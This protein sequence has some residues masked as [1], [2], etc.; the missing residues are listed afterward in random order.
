MR[1][2]TPLGLTDDNRMGDNSWHPAPPTSKD[3]GRSRS[4]SQQD[5]KANS[6]SEFV[7]REHVVITFLGQRELFRAMAM[8]VLA[9]TERSSTFNRADLLTPIY[10]SSK[11][12]GPSSSSRRATSKTAPGPARSRS[13]LGPSPKPQS[14][15]QSRSA[16]RSR[17]RSVSFSRPRSR[18]LSVKPIPLPNVEIGLPLPD[19]DSSGEDDLLIEGTPRSPHRYY[20]SARKCR[21]S[22]GPTRL[23]N[24]IKWSSSNT[25]NRDDRHDN[26]DD[27]EDAEMQETGADDTFAFLNRP[28][29]RTFA[30]LDTAGDDA[31]QGM[32][33]SEAP[34]DDYGGA[35]DFGDIDDGI[36]DGDVEE[37]PQVGNES[38]SAPEVVVIP[39]TSSVKSEYDDNNNNDL[40]S[41]FEADTGD[42]YGYFEE[43][44]PEEPRPTSHEFDNSPRKE[45]R[46]EP[47][48][49][50]K[51]D[52]V[53][54]DHLARADLG[55]VN[56]ASIRT[57]NQD[58][59]P[60]SAAGDA[61]VTESTLHPFSPTL[62]QQSSLPWPTTSNSQPLQASFAYRQ[63]LSSLPPTSST[64]PEKRQRLPTVSVSP[65]KR[66]LF[67]DSPAP[68]LPPVPTAPTPR[69]PTPGIQNRAPW[70]SPD[71]GD[72]GAHVEAEDEGDLEMV[73]EDEKLRNDD[74]E[75]DYDEDG[76]DLEVIDDEKPRHVDGELD[77]DEDLAAD[78][79]AS[80]DVSEPAGPIVEEEESLELDDHQQQASAVTN[81]PRLV[82]RRSLA[83][84]LEAVGEP[85]EKGI[86]T[87]YRNFPEPQVANLSISRTFCSA[88]PSARSYSVA[89]SRQFLR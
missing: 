49:T 27:D 10:L 77:C 51:E 65:I 26:D 55:N 12:G 76:S 32:P 85:Y 53:F 1:G 57:V 64:T 25:P 54:N 79:D 16:S 70:F 48:I 4:L 15:P 78:S 50:V 7:E 84:E 13:L 63:K 22:P 74:R 88:Q 81:Q 40:S 61:E 28:S 5:S 11:E 35:L 73:D 56:S 83:E 66:R 30:E 23:K 59:Q 87:N 46:E 19:P 21:T 14:R 89:I 58:V 44:G 24:E 43:V 3:L 62:Q 20:S 60:T 39:G 67:L 42:V 47:R 71:Q 45:E 33:S 8:F 29:V 18:S 68:S 31:P 75:L 72:S 36:S 80:S 41:S 17:A 2:R 52:S 82:R 37:E 86:S 9:L 6:K 38:I 34:W 69:R